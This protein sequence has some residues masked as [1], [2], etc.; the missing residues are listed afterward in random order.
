M[1]SGRYARAMSVLALVLVTATAAWAASLPSGSVRSST[2]KNGQVRTPD[3]ARKAI[4]GARVA[5]GSLTAAVLAKGVARR[6]LKGAPGGPGGPGVDAAIGPDAVDDQVVALLAP[7]DIDPGASLPVGLNPGAYTAE[8]GTMAVFAARVTLDHP[9]GACTGTQSLALTL[10][11]G[12]VAVGLASATA[13]GEV[14]LS[15]SGAIDIAGSGTIPIT[16]QASNYCS[17]AWHIGAAHVD[18][19]HVN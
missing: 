15:S 4:N 18:V 10:F 11:A 19:V 8:P 6:G 13:A 12:R 14:I 2:I 16:M 9:S 17:G 3:L 7:V 1:R 5:N